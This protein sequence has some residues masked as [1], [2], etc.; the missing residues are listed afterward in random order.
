MKK[1]KSLIPDINNSEREPKRSKIEIKV[2]KE[3]VPTKYD[4]KFNRMFKPFNN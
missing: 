2:D 3:K 1:I 4:D